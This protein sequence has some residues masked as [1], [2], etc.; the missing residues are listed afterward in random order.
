LAK[1]PHLHVV[2]LAAASLPVIVVNPRQVRDFAKAMGTLAKTDRLNAAIL[3]HFA[4]AVRPQIRPLADPRHRQLAEFISRRRQLVG[5]LVS[6]KNPWIPLGRQRQRDVRA[7]IK[8]LL[9][10]TGQAPW[11]SYRRVLAFRQWGRR[12]IQ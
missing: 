3:A 8:P 12:T 10:M 7:H 5:M 4:E 1:S 2:A 11:R 9:L 6:E